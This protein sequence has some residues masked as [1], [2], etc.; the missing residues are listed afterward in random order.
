MIAALALATLVAWS[1]NAHAQEK[2]K[3]KP[4]QRPA[5]GES[6]RRPNAAQAERLAKI[7]EDLK[8]TD[9]QITKLKPLLQEEAKKV[10]ALR[11]DTSLSPQDRRAK[12]R[13][14]REASAPKLKE[15]LTKE[16][17]EQWVKLRTQRP[18][19]SAG[20]KGDRQPKPPT[21]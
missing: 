12:M 5:P 15:I 2:K 21:P 13:E 18:A 19:A 11:D 8:L 7:K 6:A 16:Q 17:Y 20:Q 1:P 14:I 3:D 4:P 10:R 9:E